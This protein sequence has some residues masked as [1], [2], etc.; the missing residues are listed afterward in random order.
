MS[1]IRKYFDDVSKWE[2]QQIFFAIRSS[3]PILSKSLSELLKYLL[4]TQVICKPLAS[5][6]YLGLLDYYKMFKMQQINKSNYFYVCMFVFFQCLFFMIN[7]I[8]L[9]KQAKPF[10][11]KQSKIHFN[12]KKKT[13]INKAQQFFS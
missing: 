11:N 4:E 9:L 6:L 8:K 3:I 13:I 10:S 7:Q 12:R 2:R 1:T 5:F